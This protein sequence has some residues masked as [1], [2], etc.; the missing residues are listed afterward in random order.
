MSVY[1]QGLLTPPDEEE[2]IYPYRRVWRSLII[3]SAVVFGA[4]AAAS[5]RLRVDRHSACRAAVVPVVNAALVAL[6]VV[7]WLIFSVWRERFALEPRSRLIAVF[8]ITALAAN[9]VAIPL[10]DNVFQPERWLPLGGAINRIIGYTFTVGIVQEMIKYAVVRFTTWPDLFRT[11]LDGVAYCCR[12]RRRLRVSS[13]ICVSCSRQPSVPPDVIAMQVFNNV[14]VNLAASLIVS[15]GLSEVRFDTPT[16]FLMTIT[17]ALGALIN[18][19]AIPLRSGLTNAAFVLASSSETPSIFSVIAATF[20]SHSSTPKP[21]PGT[22]F[23]RCAAGRCRASSSPS[24]STTRNARPANWLP[25]VRTEPHDPDRNP[26]T[27]QRHQLN[28]SAGVTIS[29]LSTPCL[30]CSSASTCAMRRSYATV[31]YS[32]SEVGIRAYYPERWLID[33]AGNYVFRVRD[34]EHIGF[35][36]T[37]QVNVQPVTLSTSAR[38]L[39]QTL[40]LTRMQTLSRFR[41]LSSQP[42]TLPG[43]QEATAMGYVYVAGEDDPFP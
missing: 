15:Y 36:T 43:E 34:I 6:P 10:I 7:L 26:R 22:R 12:Q 35:K 30:R 19:I 4:A 39:L 5:I 3:E 14:A 40:T 25:A 33:T 17:V 24:C 18:G 2:I 11:R 31:P 23:L 32:N 8:V 13:S 28:A 29:S 27:P 41:V 1:K 9:A 16:P 20:S 21:S 42:Y 38:N 37:I